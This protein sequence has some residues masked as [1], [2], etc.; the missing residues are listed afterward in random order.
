MLLDK[1]LWSHFKS[2]TFLSLFKRHATKLFC[3][4]AL[5][6]FDG[7]AIPLRSRFRNKVKTFLFTCCIWSVGRT[8]VGEGLYRD[9]RIIISLIGHLLIC[10]CRLEHTLLCNFCV[11]YS[12][13]TCFQ[14]RNN[15]TKLILYILSCDHMSK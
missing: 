9:N 10:L 13:H 1:L 3:C 11:S 5:K 6:I 4:E 15:S 7:I 12:K 2:I 8:S 14:L